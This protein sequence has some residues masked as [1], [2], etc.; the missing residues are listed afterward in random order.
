MA[1][2]ST[3][4][5]FVIV[6]S[7]CAAEV[8]YTSDFNFRVEPGGRT[9]FYEKGKAGQMMEVYYQVLDGQHGDLDISLDV[10]DPIGEKI[11]SDYKK[12]QNAII[13]DLVLDGVYSVCLD[14]TYSIM[15]SKLVFVYV[16][17]EDQASETPE[18]E[19]EVSVVDNEGNEVKQVEAL[20]WM[21]T[22]EAGEP[23]YIAV[24]HVADSMSRTL[25]HVVKARHM[26][27]MYAA[28]KS[29]DSYVA[30]EETF[31]VDMWSG[32]QISFMCV[33]GLV[34][35]YMIKKLFRSPKDLHN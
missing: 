2:S 16:M 15:N 10:I 31:V 29:R 19:A 8:M 34:Q 9:C 23:Y 21:G 12:S 18:P 33:V 25:R 17:I 14:N 5:V 20:H 6:L 11:V 26:L 32:F 24:E 30:F 4:F 7:K 35:V 27:D 1:C 28:T 3:I 22:D 13:K